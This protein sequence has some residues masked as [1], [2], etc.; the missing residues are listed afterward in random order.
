MPI[1]VDWN[2]SIPQS[3]LMSGIGLSRLGQAGNTR[4]FRLAWAL[5]LRVKLMMSPIQSILGRARKY[6]S[7]FFFDQW[8]PSRASS[9]ILKYG[10]ADK[11]FVSSTRQSFP[12]AFSIGIMLPQHQQNPVQMTSMEESG[13]GHVILINCHVTINAPNISSL[14]IKILGKHF[15]SPPPPPAMEPPAG[16]IPVPPPPPADGTKSMISPVVNKKMALPSL[17][18]DLMS[19]IRE[20]I[21]LKKVRAKSRRTV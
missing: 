7:N 9:D 1:N 19:A 10:N 11:G 13:S 6:I 12:S 8:Q 17:P 21:A 3:L 2:K 4:H 16:Y 15:P 20:G 5:V 18:A 14:G